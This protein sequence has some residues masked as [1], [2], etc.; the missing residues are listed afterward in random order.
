[1]S[2]KNPPAAPAAGPTP[3]FTQVAWVLLDWA[4]SGFSTVL[5]TL[6]VAYIEKVAFADRPWG[7]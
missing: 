2:S 6:L 4:A 5:I 7:L 3:R 1:M